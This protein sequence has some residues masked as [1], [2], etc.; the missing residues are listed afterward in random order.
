MIPWVKFFVDA[1]LTSAYHIWKSRECAQCVGVTEFLYIGSLVSVNGDIKLDSVPI[2]NGAKSAFVSLY[3]VSSMW[4]KNV[5][6]V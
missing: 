4:K 3:K 2:M 6:L 5:L 1:A